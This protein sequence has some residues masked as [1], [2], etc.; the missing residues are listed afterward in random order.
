MKLKFFKQTTPFFFFFF[1]FLKSKLI[2]IIP[3]KL[4]KEK[5]S[6][7]IPQIK[8]KKIKNK[9]FIEGYNFNEEEKEEKK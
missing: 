9:F 1:F 2:A 3:Q 7:F 4:K 5:N 8:K 6:I